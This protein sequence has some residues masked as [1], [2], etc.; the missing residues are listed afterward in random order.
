M[1][2][3]VQVSG[4]NSLWNNLRRWLPGLLISAVLLWLILRNINWPKVG[5]AFSL[6]S[7][8]EIFLV[9]LIY[10]I[11]L[12][13]RVFCWYTLLQW[14]APFKRVFLVMGE[15]Y[16]LNNILPLRLGEVGRA[17]LLGKDKGMAIFKVLPTIVV[18][19]AYDLAV[20][21]V[22]LLATLPLVLKMN[23]S[24]PLA[25][26]MLVVV[27]LGLFSLYWMARY[28]E[29]VESFAA[30]MGARWKFF[31]KWILPQVEAVLDGFA[32]LTRPQYFALSLGMMIVS[33]GLA[34]VQDYVIMHAL[35]PQAPI[36]W[37]GFVI[38][39]GALG[40]AIPSA[41][42]ALGVFEAAAVGALLLV[43]MDY[44]KAFTFAIC[45]HLTSIIF[46]TIVGAVGLI[47]E[48]ESLTTLYQS[49]S[50]RKK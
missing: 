5:Q 44:E 19:R 50:T 23:S 8:G 22:L 47:Q 42:A 30:K 12:S 40:A 43:G 10:Y 24:R 1:K 27:A 11:S 16:L 33:W 15:G 38:S 17:V 7:P 49:L 46:S 37:V 25:I 41:P 3:D 2:A 34:L 6:I 31:T 45:A 35:D 48:G 39:A 14:K 21:A 9:I 28:R 20:A 29:R 4:W 13:A 32:V 18:E 26:T 36:W